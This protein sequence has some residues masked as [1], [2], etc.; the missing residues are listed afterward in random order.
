MKKVNLNIIVDSLAFT[1]FMFLVSTGTLLHY[2]LPPG[3]GRS[4]AIWGMN[5]HE[6]GEVHLV[7]AIALLAILALHLVLHWSWI[8]ALVKGR[9][10]YATKY[11]IALGLVALLSLIA[12]AAAPLVSK[13]EQTER[14]GIEHEE[15][16]R[17][18]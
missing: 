8:S 17:E 14:A 9:A 3:S 10:A 16:F 13:I 7:I 15:Q 4:R 18:K 12:L 2:L 1:G 11:R 6:W 5:R